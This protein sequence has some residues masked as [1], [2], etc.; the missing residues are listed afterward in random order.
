MYVLGKPVRFTDP[1]GRQPFGLGLLLSNALL[2]AG[3][4]VFSD[5]C[6]VVTASGSSYNFFTGVQGLG[7]LLHARAVLESLGL[8]PEGLSR[9]PDVQLA[10]EVASRTGRLRDVLETLVTVTS[11]KSLTDVAIALTPLKFSPKIIRQMAR[12]GWTKE[13]I[14][15]ARQA[16]TH[17]RAVSKAT[18]NTATRYVHPTTG[19][20]VVVDDVTGDV[21]HVGGE[22]FKYGPGSGD[23]P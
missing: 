6:I 13:A 23:I 5:D 15:E 14:H 3:C 12:R 10:S 18:G 20:S 21:I 2:N 1:S 9:D 7:D 16:G 17:V 19:K 4:S 8:D 11:G 22:G